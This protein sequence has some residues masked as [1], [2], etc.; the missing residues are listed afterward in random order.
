MAATMT[1]VKLDPGVEAVNTIFGD[2]GQFL[3]IWA[4]L[5]R[6]CAKYIHGVF[7]KTTMLLSLFL[8]K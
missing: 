2:L 6:F 4:Y 7:L 5:G 8:P 1:Q 3:A